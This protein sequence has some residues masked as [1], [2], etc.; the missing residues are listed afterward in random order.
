MATMSTST[1][2]AAIEPVFTQAERLAVAGFLAGYTGL[3]CGNP[4]MIRIT[5]AN[6]RSA[7]LMSV[8]LLSSR[9]R[10]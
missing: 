10:V 7:R 1:A 8:S 2:V 6:R 4:G 5:F 3:T 9:P